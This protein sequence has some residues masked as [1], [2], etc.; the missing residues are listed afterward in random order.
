M[1]VPV[2]PDELDVGD[3]G[4]SSNDLVFGPDLEDAFRKIEGMV[5]ELENPEGWSMSSVVRLIWQEL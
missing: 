1:K 4:L 5:D 3:E 2:N